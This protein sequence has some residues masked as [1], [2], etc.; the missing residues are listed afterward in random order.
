MRNGQQHHV[1]TADRFRHI[2]GHFL[3]GVAVITAAAR[4]R[5]FGTTASALA[6]VSLE[7]PMLLICLNRDS[8]TGRAI[9][10]AGS[11]A[12]NLL[13]EHQGEL[14]RRFATKEEDKFAGLGMLEGASGQPLI[15]GVLAHLECEVV[16]QMTGGT[17]IV[18]LSYVTKGTAQAG[19]PLAYYRGRFGRLQLAEPALR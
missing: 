13:H 18:F 17:H 3:S 2:I 14:A 4:G 7:P 10:H 8:S 5:R 16:E 11:F 19:M 9:S 6:S 1:M 12:I 15:D